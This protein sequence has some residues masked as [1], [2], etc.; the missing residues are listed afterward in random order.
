MQTY[1]GIFASST[2]PSGQTLSLTIE[3]GSKVII[4]IIGTL[5]ALKGIDSIAV[6]TQLQQFVDLGVTLIPVGY[7][8]WHT[9][10]LMYGIVRKFFVKAA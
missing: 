8:T 10:Q 3:S 4:G 6:T 5:V 9:L 2:D 1:K 7:T